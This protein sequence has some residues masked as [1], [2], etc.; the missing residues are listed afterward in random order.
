MTSPAPAPT[1]P[2]PP[3]VRRSPLTIPRPAWPAL[4]VLALV[5]VNVAF[6]LARFGPSG[7]FSQGA[8]LHLTFSPGFASGATIDI[9]YNG[10]KAMIL[11][12]GMTLVIGG[13]GVDLSVGSI[14]AV[15]AAIAVTLVNRGVSP[16]VA[17]SAAITASSLCGL[18]NGMLVA[19][20]RLQP[21]VA[22]LVFM[23]AGRGLAQMITGGQIP[24]FQNQAL[25]YIGLGKLLGLPFPFIL[26]MALFAVTLLAVRKTALGLLLEAVGGNPEAARLAGVRSRTLIAFTYV[27][28]GFCAG[29]AG[30]LAAADIK[31]ADP[32][33]AGLNLELAAVFA[34]VVGGTSLTGGRF[35]LSGAL[36][37]AL[38]LQTLITTM[39]TRDVSSDVA[40]LPQA[41]VILLVCVAASPQLPAL[42]RKLRS[43]SSA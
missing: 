11:A 38:L 2:P 39:Y 20:L 27:A 8:F 1:P 3:A 18:W 19:F 17:M 12:I 25:E 6:D 21:F 29:L 14:M 4:G 28:S 16:W 13:G 35:S 32:F 5:L 40:P 33:H 37:G 34:V 31:G 42:L 23:V 26:V 24:T 15:S 9:L 7:L 36:I 10:A 30:L 43:G 22:T 41:L